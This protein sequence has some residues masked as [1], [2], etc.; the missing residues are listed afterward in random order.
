MSGWSWVLY[1]ILILLV[2]SWDQYMFSQEP[3]Q[4]A[5][6]SHF[7]MDDSDLDDEF[8]HKIDDDSD[9]Q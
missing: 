9:V 1:Y 3:E 7:E 8:V 5:N 4:I 2:S 6:K